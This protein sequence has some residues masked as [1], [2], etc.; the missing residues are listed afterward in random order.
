MISGLPE[1]ALPRISRGGRRPVVHVRDCQTTE[2]LPGIH[3][4]DVAVV[5]VTDDDA[6]CDLATPA[7]TSVTHDRVRL[8]SRALSED[9]VRVCWQAGAQQNQR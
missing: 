6:L 5:T 8:F 3:P 2:R 9:E 1:R 4:D 7:V